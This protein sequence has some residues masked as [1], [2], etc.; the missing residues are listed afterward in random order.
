MRIMRGDKKRIVCG[1]DFS[2]H[3]AE[4][5]DV[6]AAIAKRLD[7]AV[8]LV[9]VEEQGKLG[10]SHPETFEELR[11]R[12]RKRLDAEAERLR[13]LGATVKEE[14]VTGSAYEALV[15]VAS[16]PSTRLLVVSSLGQIAPS[17]FLLGSVAERTAESSPVPTLVVKDPGP[18]KDWVANK[19][20]L[21]I[22]V[23]DDFSATSEAALRW[24]NDLR[25]IAPCKVTV[26]HVNWPP[27]DRE[28]L[29]V[30][31]PMAMTENPVEVQRVLERD[32]TARA[33]D[34]FGGGA[35]NVHVQPGWGR[36]DAHLIALA[37]SEGAH[38]IVVGT[39]QRHGVSRVWLGSVSRGILHQASVSVAVVPPPIASGDSIG[40]IP[41]FKRV[42][43]PTDFS[44][45]GNDAIPYAYATLP[46]GATVKLI[47]VKSPWALPG[48]SMP[49]HQPERPTE[50][51]DEQ[52]ACDSLKKLYSLIPS[53]AEARGIVSACEVVE[54]RDVGLA[55]S[56][57]AERFGADLICIGSHG[58]SGLAK[59]LLG[60]VAQAVIAQSK[61]PVLVIRPKP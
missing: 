3:A 12:T 9:H 59:A 50:K 28:R 27:E 61:R 44:E 36:A 60:S 45:P 49:H 52:L 22:L 35:V 42:L 37:A 47:H 41:E 24:V 20:P 34:L 38:L 19:A 30:S 21:K 2:V 18:F 25:R 32:L 11:N 17:R 57:E 56:Q 29:G 4:A 53:Q 10:A 14:L 54:S 31:G 23:G 58:R 1:T 40:R 55:I 26:A 5:A 51:H 8:V 48:P 15:D 33:T 7:E 6:A 46:R 13:G 16:R 43:V 39:H